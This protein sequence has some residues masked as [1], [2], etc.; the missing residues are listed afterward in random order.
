MQSRAVN[1]STVLNS[2]KYTPGGQ[3][4]VQVGLDGDGDGDP[5]GN[6]WLRILVQDTGVGIPAAQQKLIR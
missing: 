5:A 1:S 6:G 2:V 3:V 4:L